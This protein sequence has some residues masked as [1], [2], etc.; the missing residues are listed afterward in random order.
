MTTRVMVETVRGSQ[1]F[2]Q[3]IGLATS[4]AS[5]VLVGAVLLMA[6]R[7][8]GRQH[9]PALLVLLVTLLL[10]SLVVLSVDQ[11][12]VALGFEI[13]VLGLGLGVVTV[14]QAATDST[15]G[16][17]WRN[18][19]P[20]LTAAGLVVGGILLETDSATGFT[21]IFA[22]IAVGLAVAVDRAWAMVTSG[23]G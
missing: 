19:L 22:A 10:A 1:D 4:I 3:A 21:W 9:G 7:P 8:S 13:S 11:S 6:I 14:V 23:P 20:M 15:T 17:R 5:A 12:E 18:A 2:W 16:P